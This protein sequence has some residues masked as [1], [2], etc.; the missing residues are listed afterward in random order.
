M[1]DTTTGAARK[2]GLATL[3][4]PGMMVAATG[5]GAG[6]LAAATVGGARFGLV[7]IWAVVLGAFFKF[8]LNEGLARW[9]LATDK[10]ILEGWAEYLPRWVQVYFGAY[11]LIWTVAVSVAMANACG[12]G[13]SNLTGGAIPTSWGAVIHSLLGGAL[14][15]IGGF[16]GFEKL[17]RALIA[18]MVVGIVACAVLTFQDLS[19][20]FRGLFVPTIPSGSTTSLLA[21]IGGVGG[22]ITVINYNYWMREEKISG[23]GSLRYV[24]IDL[25]I[26]YT[27][28]AVLAIAVLMMANRAF[29]TSGV[30]LNSA[31][32]VPQMAAMLGSTVGGLGSLA[33][34]I[35]FWGATASSLLGVWQGVPYMF[36][37]IY[38]IVRKYPKDVRDRFKQVT[39]TPYRIALAAMTLIPIPFA[40]LNRPL[41]LL[42]TYT[43]IGSFFFPFLSA[44]L[45]YLN[46]KIAWNSPVQKNGWA[47]N[48]VLILVLVF[49]AVIAVQDIVNAF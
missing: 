1:A 46:N 30:E 44:T 13:I 10:T 11:L 45:L 40:F 3:I 36:A 43:I 28:T 39:S 15:W 49:F 7:L 31:T 47:T 18:V 29:F 35:G 25:L 33:Y 21:L 8:V 26:A 6:D 16:R 41:L 17:M 14:V 32:A 9:Q 37:D 24:R 23:A 48:A 38:G 34:S 4:G 20:V 22:T 2:F 27:V 19:G 12:L 42:I 5:V